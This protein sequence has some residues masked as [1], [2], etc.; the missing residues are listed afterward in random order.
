MLFVVFA[1]S[2][3]GVFGPILIANFVK[4]K[5]NLFLTILKQ[6]GTGVIIS[7]AFIHVGVTSPDRLDRVSY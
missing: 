6:F 2:S 5:A 3:I 1:A 4:V 7:T